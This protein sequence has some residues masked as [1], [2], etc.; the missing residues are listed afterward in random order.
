MSNS[1]EDNGEMTFKEWELLHN[2]L[3]SNKYEDEEK[4][5]VF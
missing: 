2:Y 1:Y 4:F 3:L 5:A